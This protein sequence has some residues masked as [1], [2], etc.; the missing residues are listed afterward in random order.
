MAGILSV[1]NSANNTVGGIF[2]TINE[3]QK[4]VGQFSWSGLLDAIIPDWLQNTMDFITGSGDYEGMSLSERIDTVFTVPEWLQNVYDFL[5]GGGSYTGMSLSDRISTEFEVPEWLQSV[6]DFLTGG[7][8]YE[9]MTLSERINTEFTVPEWLQNVYDFL[10][11]G[12]DYEGMTLNDRIGTEFE[13]PTWLSSIFNFISG[14][15]D[16]EGMKLKDR[17]NT[18]F[19]TPTWLSSIFNFIKGES[20]FAGKLKIKDRLDLSFELPTAFQTIVDFFK[21]EATFS[22]VKSDMTGWVA[23]IGES[24]A[25]RWNSIMD[26]MSFSKDIQIFG[27]TYSL[28]LDLSDWKITIPALA[29]GGIVNGPTLA[30][31]GEAGP[32]AVLPLSGENARKA[33]MAMGG[34]GG[35]FNITINAGGIT[36]RTDKRA[37][38]RELGNMVQQEL[39]R[40]VG[41]ATMRG[42]F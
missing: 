31:I 6:Y 11:G 32:E 21:G 35:T 20:G 16:Y 10:T 18:E 33:G 34:G 30:M 12:G 27:E 2:G 13:T 8:D 3:M 19:E 36:D 38:A 42:R 29:A 41:G 7:G 22:E 5:T 26:L 40:T 25:A 17:I 39:A 14:S 37:L 4:L 1:L 15:G 23:G 24:L 28:G 9:G